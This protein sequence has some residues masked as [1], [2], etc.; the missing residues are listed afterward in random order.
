MNIN[1]WRQFDFSLGV[2]NATTWLLKKPNELARGL[3]LRFTET[4]GGFERR[5]GFAR[6]GDQFSSANAPQGGHIAKFSNGSRRFVAVNN[7]ADTATIIRSQDSGTGAWTTLS[8]I[9]TWPVD[10]IMFFI[11]YLDEVYVTGFDPATGDPIQPVNINKDL[12]VSTTRNILSMPSGYFLE[13]YLGLLYVANVTVGSTRYPDRVY[14]SS[15]PLGAMTYIQGAQ[16][17]VLTSTTFV[18]NTPSMT[19]SSSP[20]GTVA[21]STTYAGY[22]AYAAFD[23]LGTRVNSW[24]T[25]SGNTTG[26]V[27]YDFG[28]GVTKTITHYSLTPLASDMNSGDEKWA[29]KSWTLEGSNN[30]SSWTTLDT[31]STQP[32]WVASEKRM[33]ST[34]NTTAYRYYRINVSDIQ[35]SSGTN[36]V[37]INEIE[38]LTSLTGAQAIEIK[39]D[40]VRY[41]KAGD[42]IDIYKAGTSTKL[43][44][45]T[46]ATVDKVRNVITVTPESRT[47]AT[48]DVNTTTEVITITGANT[49]PTGTPIKFSSTSAV[50]AGLVAET[51]Y[52]AINVSS[53]T[54]KVATTLDNA[55]L[56]NAINLTSTGTGTHTVRMS[57]VFSDND[58]IWLDGTKGKLNLFWNTDYPNPE[59]TGEYLGIKPGTD[60]NN[61]ISAIKAS[62]NRLFIWTKNS[63]TRY[64]G[65]NLIVF[66]KAV[67]CISQRSVANIDDDWLIWVDQK[68]NVRARSENQGAQENISRAIRNDYLRKLT[69]EQLKATSAGIVDQTYKLYLGDID[70]KHIRVCYD[71]DANTWSPEELGYPALIHAN[72]DYTG[73][74]RPY[75]FSS[76]GRLYQ[77][78]IGNLDDDKKI[79][80]NAGTG[81]D[82]FQTE[83]RKKFYG[84]R[85]FTRNCNGLRVQASVDGS[86]MKTVGRIDGEVS[87]IIFAEN[88]D[89]VLDRGVA[90]DWQISGKLD[91]D[92]PKVDGAI[93][94]WIPEEDVPSGERR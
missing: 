50:P 87:T 61:T 47:F 58:E 53:T 12:D 73:I 88:G 85:L 29:P 14:K 82:M 62:S 28:S 71:F 89:N 11:D 37:T 59:Q 6:A 44:D 13:E 78:E 23:D 33:Y 54:I 57:Y 39:L 70:G 40:S 16:T 81:R 19:G 43:Y 91:G 76:N 84:I 94:Y 8:G 67:G 56:G 48:S 65:Q 32:G 20:T 38:L 3:N 46:V 45:L 86:Q 64:D 7:D 34:S 24:F 66:N 36:L 72:D 63:G 80:F 60:A 90:F 17:D 25:T 92:A 2:Q 22:N 69:L 5:S 79:T 75:F 9:P 42:A 52:Y 55:L 93:V 30:G 10:S 41:V 77:D 83:Q 4:V 49:F 1:R 27:T 51:I 74:L 35:T 18:D 68:G 15:P 21:A 31:R 26:T